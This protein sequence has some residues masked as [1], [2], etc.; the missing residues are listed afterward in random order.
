MEVLLA[1]TTMADAFTSVTSAV[2]NVITI[3][4]TGD[5][6]VFFWS[7]LLFTGVAMVKKLKH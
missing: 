1:S 6:A 2:T 4:T 3:A 7:G 5:L